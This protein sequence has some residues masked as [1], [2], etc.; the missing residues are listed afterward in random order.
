MSA[1]RFSC[2]HEELPRGILWRSQ[3]KH[4]LGTILFSCLRQA[5]LLVRLLFLQAAAVTNQNSAAVAQDAFAHQSIAGL[6][7]QP[8]SAAIRHRQQVNPSRAQPSANAHFQPYL[9]A[10][11]CTVRALPLAR[12]WPKDRSLCPPCSPRKGSLQ[13]LS[14]IVLPLAC[15][16]LISGLMPTLV[17]PT[18]MSPLVPYVMPLPKCSLTVLY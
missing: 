7:L 9:T 14:L 11:T 18:L 17:E 10:T 15:F 6:P 1:G 4:L 12:D 5:I 13:V 3:F 16:G 2:R 8:A